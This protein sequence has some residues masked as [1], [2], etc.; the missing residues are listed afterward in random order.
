[1]TVA[2]ETSAIILVKSEKTS[3]KKKIKL[4]RIV[5][6]IAIVVTI[7]SFVVDYIGYKKGQEFGLLSAT[8]ATDWVD[9]NDS[10]ADQCFSVYARLDR[11]SHDLTLDGVTYDYS[12]VR[13]SE[14][15]LRSS[16]ADLM[17][18]AGYDRYRSYDIADWFLYTNFVEYYFYYYWSQIIPI[19][20]YI[21]VLFSIVYTLLIKREEEKELVVYEDSVLCRISSKKSKQLVFDDI[22]N[23][24]FGKSTLKLVGAGI[25]FKISNLTNAE[26]IKSAII[27]KKKSMQKV[28]ETV[29]KNAPVSNAEELKKYKELLDSGVIT[30]EEFDT[31]K[32][33]LLG[34]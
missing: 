13:K 33:Q 17:E 27:E 34:L 28:E 22:N 16:F 18:S 23:V 19:I 12:D 32:K 31:K 26:E 3:Q 30:Q 9:E 5:A 14:N 4:A 11:R 1:M 7:A 8:V 29:T 15:N 21:I 2:S 25:K 20:C 24:D 6:I 10:Y